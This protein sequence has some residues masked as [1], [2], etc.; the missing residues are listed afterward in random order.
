MKAPVVD[1]EV[2]AAPVV[3]SFGYVSFGLG[4]EPLPYTLPLFG[5]GG[6]YQNGHHGFDGSIQFISFGRGLT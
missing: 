3:A 4:L 6:R 5:V 1:C 2:E